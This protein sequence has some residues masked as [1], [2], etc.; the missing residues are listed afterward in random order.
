MTK[1]K[2]NEFTLRIT[3]ANRS[4]II[5]IMY[6]IAIC[7]IED[8]IDSSDHGTLRANAVNAIKVIEDLMK[9]LDYGK[10][11]AYVLNNYYMY[12]RKLLTASIYKDSRQE[13]KRAQEYLLSVKKSFEKVAKEDTSEKIMT[14]TENIY[15]GLTYGRKALYD[16]LTTEV[17]RGY[18]I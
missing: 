11:L 1:D 4:E 9:A 2:I 14:N 13:L 18:T 16:S 12:I 7:Y 17:A 10:E 15:T 6:D 3:Q 8:A 5:V